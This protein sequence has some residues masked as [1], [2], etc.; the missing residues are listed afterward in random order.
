MEQT[1]LRLAEA[2]IEIAPADLA[3]YFVLT[4]DGFACLVEK[5]RTDPPGFGAIGSV[6]KLTEQGF[7]VVTWD[8]SQAYFTTKGGRQPATPE[9]LKSSA[10]S[11]MTSR[12]P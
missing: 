3:Q 10:A 8:A 12:L 5:T 1:L 7:A 6:C 4:R 11:K 2:K 9:E